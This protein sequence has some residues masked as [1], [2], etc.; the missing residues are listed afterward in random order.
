MQAAVAGL[1]A[2]PFVERFAW[3]ARGPFDPIMGPSALYQTN[4]QL[5]ST[6]R[7]YAS[8]YRDRPAATSCLWVTSVRAQ[9]AARD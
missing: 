4:G 1:R 9:A 8:L 2:M 5:T 6:G 3:K 7:L